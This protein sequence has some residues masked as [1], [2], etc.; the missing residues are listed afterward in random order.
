MGRK[1]RVFAAI[2]RRLGLSGK[3]RRRS[4]ACLRRDKSG[5]A[6]QAARDR[7]DA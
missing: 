3:S 4:E 6:S 5:E 7:F 2:T 1:K